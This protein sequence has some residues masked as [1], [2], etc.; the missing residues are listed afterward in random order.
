MA[1]DST[2]SALAPPRLLAGITLLYWGAMTGEA[3]IALIIAVL[4]EGK[5]WVKWSWDF[6]AAAYVKAFQ[7][8]L[9]LLGLVL[10]M[11]WLDEIN[12]DS[13]YHVMKWFPLCFLPVE[14]AQRYG[15]SDSMNLNTFFYF[16]R[17]RMKQDVKEGRS[18][19]PKKINTGY[20]Y[21]FI[22]IVVASCASRMDVFVQIGMLGLMTA[23]ILAVSV[24]RGLGWRRL[25]WAL[26]MMLLVA[27]WIQAETE[28][29]YKSYMT[30]GRAFKDPGEGESSPRH[31]NLGQ[32]G[33]M[34]QN[35]EIQWRMWGDE[36]PEYLRLNS[37]NKHFGVGWKYEYEA[38]ARGFKDIDEAFESGT[39]IEIGGD[40]TGLFIF[41][42]ELEPMVEDSSVPRNKITLRGKG[43]SDTEQSIV[44]S[45]AGLFAIDKIVGGDVTPAVHPLGVLKLINRKAII[46]YQLWSTDRNLLDSKP[47]DQ[48]DLEVIKSYKNS[49]T[50]LSKEMGLGSIPDPRDKV[51]AMGDFF[52][53]N[54]S[55]ALHFEMPR[56]DFLGSD[57][58]RFMLDDRR[59]HCEYFATTAA[60]LLREQGIPT[61]YCIGFV[62]REK[63]GDTWVMRGSHLHAWC[64][65]WID[66]KWEIV[67]LTPP[68][69]L[70]IESAKNEVEWSQGFK[71]WFQNIKQ[72]FLIWRTDDENKSLMN[73]VMW[74]LG[75]MLLIWFGYRLFKARTR[76][77][78][79]GNGM[80]SSLTYELPREFEFIEA[81][82]SSVIGERSVAQTYQNWVE[83]AKD[84]VDEDLLEKLMNLMKL[85]EKSRFGGQNMSSEIAKSSEKVKSL[86]KW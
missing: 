45:A 16:S 51:N 31:T 29:I 43:Q 67:D 22:V 40:G 19:N 28:A 64:S 10:L 66:G 72:D 55:Y 86:L 32:L 11:V 75:V 65:A 30:R 17:L 82:L 1:S 57:L 38:D 70:S 5:N 41:K 77:A 33:E 58:E 73:A 85:H 15:K 54:F 6:D 18:F 42:T 12:R 36:V 68:D 71:D 27:V 83:G 24:K 8:S 79:I 14:L 74:V 4:L 78:D 84:K 63:D 23:I 69:W 81:K 7:V 3:F 49:V 48:L 2:L 60:L 56:T 46:D 20:P 9:G 61:R 76:K 44:P 52:M 13:L 80:A 37:Y 21:L 39:G 25:V 26:P 34:K 53:Q 47:D 59:G 50:L 62:A 35:P